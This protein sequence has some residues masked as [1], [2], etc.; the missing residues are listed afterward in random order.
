MM[1]QTCLSPGLSGVQETMLWALHDRAYAAKQP[2]GGFRDPQCV[3]I[4][5]SID[6]EFVSRFGTPRS[7]LAAAR[8]SMIDRTLRRWVSSHPRGFVVSLGEGLETQAYRVDNGQIRWLSVDL[9]DAIEFRERFMKPTDRFKHAAMSAFDPRWMNHVDDRSGV[10]VIAQGLLMYFRPDEVRK[11]LAAIGR[12]FPGS[13]M[14]FDLVARP[15]SEATQQGHDV[16][17][18]FTSPVMPFGLNRDEAVPTLR[19]WLP[20]AKA[21]SCR[22]LRPA[23]GRPAILENVLD[24]VLP[25]RQKLPSLVHVRF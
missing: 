22:R 14:M 25:H 2:N 16:T 11:L 24:A 7:N 10:F 1:R 5:D 12:R 20:G 17:A 19:S 15:L 23:S 18:H 21:I 4:Y 8:A 13:E 9:M 6:Y 3:N